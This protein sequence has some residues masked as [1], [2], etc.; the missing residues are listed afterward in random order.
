MLGENSAA[1][2]IANTVE[3]KQSAAFGEYNNVYA[4]DSIAAGNSCVIGENGKSTFCLGRVLKSDVPYQTVV[5]QYNN[6][7]A[8]ALFV[9]G[10]GTE[11]ASWARKNAFEVYADGHSEVQLVSTDSDLSVINKQY[12]ES[13]LSKLIGYGTGEPTDTSYKFWI[14]IEK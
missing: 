9:V 1:F 4:K 2:N 6:P 10:N 14:Q 3:G 8:D 5:G 13:E 7:N 11:N 12:L